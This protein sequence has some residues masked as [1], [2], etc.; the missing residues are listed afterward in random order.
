M[1]SKGH[2]TSAAEPKPDTVGYG[3]HDDTGSKRGD[4]A[5]GAANQLYPILGDTVG[6]ENQGDAETAFTG[7]VGDTAISIW[8]VQAAPA[9]GCNTFQPTNEGHETGSV[10]TGPAAASQAPEAAGVRR[11]RRRR[12]CGNLSSRAVNIFI[13]SCLALYLINF[14]VKMIFPISFLSFFLSPLPFP[15]PGVGAAT[16]A[17]PDEHYIVFDEVG[18]V[19]S[20]M[21]YIH[22]GLPLN[23]TTLQDQTIVIARY[24]DTI[25]N[26]TLNSSRPTFARV[27]KDLC[28]N[29]DLKLQRVVQKMYKIEALLPQDESHREQFSEYEAS[30]RSKRFVFLPAYLVEQG[31]H[32]ATKSALHDVLQSNIKLRERIRELENITAH[33]LAEPD[34]PPVEE[35]VLTS[36]SVESVSTPTTSDPTGYHHTREKRVALL[37][38]VAGGA[39]LAGVLGTFLGLYSTAEIVALKNSINSIKTQQNLLVQITNDHER[40]LQGLT[41]AMAAMTDVVEALLA[42]NP[43]LLYAQLSEQIDLLDDRI[44]HSVSAIQQ[45][46]HRRLSVDF[47]SV[48][49]LSLLH[50]HVT[51]LA[52]HQGYELLPTHLSD[53]FQLETSYIRHNEDIVILVHVPCILKE[54]LLKIYRFVPYPFPIEAELSNL[55]LTIGENLLLTR[56]LS[57]N[58]TPTHSTNTPINQAQALFVQP[59][60]EFLAVGRDN[61]FKILTDSEFRMCD[62]RSRTFLCEQHQVLRTD[63]GDSCLGALFLRNKEGIVNNCRFKR[64]ILRETVYQ[65]SPTD[66]LVYTPVPFTAQI[67]CRNG[68]HQPLFLAKNTRI[69][70]SQ[71]C[72]VDLRAH[73]I[74]SDFNIRTTPEPLRSVWTFDPMT[75][76]A[77]MLDDTAKADRVLL[78]VNKQVAQLEEMA[79]NEHRANMLNALIIH[80]LSTY[81]W[82]I[83]MVI[84]LAVCLALG[85]AVAIILHPSCQRCRCFH[86]QQPPPYQQQLSLQHLT[87]NSTHCVHGNLYGSCCYKP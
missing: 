30:A 73:T 39:L 50:T 11:G 21:A 37:P 42:H 44:T 69:H 63:M 65:L 20:S 9:S 22:V 78:H 85:G 49:G 48:E 16:Y 58:T 46:Q 60:A 15:F 80:D 29:L 47:L 41:K 17:E 38:F 75:L 10:T 1:D 23:L 81:P 59:E 18:E 82:W 66:H 34:L 74:R 62:K 25:S 26:I 61:K 36:L 54:N 57:T 45:L 27:L 68:S 24:M 32:A 6:H 35:F 86:A 87:S 76:P 43:T 4:A 56:T 8:T 31:H 2:E 13:L 84:V 19:A 7:G 77:S 70:I 14:F 64:K 83:W 51:K 5:A 79:A 55:N 28:R 52:K 40:M 12:R 3:P 67:Q 72:S 53:Y 71:G 33:L